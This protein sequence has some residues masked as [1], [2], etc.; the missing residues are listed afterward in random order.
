MKGAMSG[1][2]AMIER[3]LGQKKGGAVKWIKTLDWTGNT[4]ND[5]NQANMALGVWAAEA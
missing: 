1:G 4:Q 5:I 3:M 2:V